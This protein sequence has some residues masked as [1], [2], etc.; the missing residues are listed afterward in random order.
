VTFCVEETV[1]HVSG[2][3]AL[4]PPSVVAVAF[5]GRQGV[6]GVATAAVLAMST[7]WLLPRVWG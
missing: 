6:I 1:S 7:L 4:L 2:V 3:S 5:V